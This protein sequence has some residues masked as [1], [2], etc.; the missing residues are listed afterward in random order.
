MDFGV[1]SAACIFNICAFLRMIKQLKW[2]V[3]EQPLYV[4][5]GQNEFKNQNICFFHKLEDCARRGPIDVVLLSGVLQYLE[6]PYGTL[7]QRI[8]IAKN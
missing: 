1:D 8:P 3:V 5:C 6:H 4:A 2:S 7:S